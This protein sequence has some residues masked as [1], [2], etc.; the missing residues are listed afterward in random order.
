MTNKIA[1]LLMLTAAIAHAEEP[2]LSSL[3]G[4]LNAM[5]GAQTNARPVEVVDFREL[6]ALLPESVGAYK[7]T[8]AS[9]EKSGAMGMTISQAIGQYEAGK[10]QLTIKLMDYGGTGFASVMAAAW[11]TTEIDRETDD[12]YERSVKL[13][14]H[15]GIEKYDNAS[16][17]GEL[18]V[19]VGSRFMVEINVRDGEPADLTAA[20]NAL[21]LDKLAALK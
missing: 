12:G 19:L 16:R 17:F 8:K 18:Q 2:N 11:T 7:R 20:A 13:G 4:A 14:A 15:R 6:R 21:A 9:G 5:I 10:A 1:F 3:M